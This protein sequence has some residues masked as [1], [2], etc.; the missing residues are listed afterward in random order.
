MRVCKPATWEAEAGKLKGQDQPG[1][2]SES[3]KRGNKKNQNKLGAIA[4]SVVECLP[5]CIKTLVQS[6]GLWKVRVLFLLHV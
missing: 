5:A 3:L 1:Q 2:L 6:P 4:Q